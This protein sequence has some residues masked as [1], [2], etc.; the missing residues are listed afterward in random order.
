MMQNQVC[1]NLREGRQHKF[2]RA[3]K[4]GFRDPVLYVDHTKYCDYSNT[5]STFNITYLLLSPSLCIYVFF[6]LLPT[7]RCY[8]LSLWLTVS[9]FGKLRIK[10]LYIIEMAFS[11][12][13]EI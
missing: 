7:N 10:L 4:G 11:F 13:V 2:V 6:K 3:A 9:V 8:F 1:V 12:Q 5:G